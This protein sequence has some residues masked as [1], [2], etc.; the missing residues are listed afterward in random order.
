MKNIDD[1]LNPYYIRDSLPIESKLLVPVIQVYENVDSTSNVLMEKNCIY[2]NGHTCFAEKQL[3]GRG[4]LE[5]SWLTTES[6]VCFSVAW[7]Y[8]KPLEIPHMLNYFVAIKLVDE[9]TQRGFSGI[10]TKWPND[11]IYEGAKLGGI[12]IDA[13]HRKDS[14]LYLVVG[15]GVNL[16]TSEAD[17][18]NIDQ[19]ISDLIS[20]SSDPLADRNKIASFLLHAVIQ[21]LSEF[22]EYDFRKISEDW[23][24]M[25]YNLNKLKTIMVKNKKIKTTLKGINELGQLCCFHDDKINLYNINEVRIIKDEF[26]RN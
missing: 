17:K 8:E 12:L 18:S 9:L 20:T 5:K 21:S 3:N 2:P 11:I 10:K 23:N 26:L 22:K 4:M 15:V 1:L 25:D 7:N 24:N 14:K 16:K 13:V 19:K 6:N